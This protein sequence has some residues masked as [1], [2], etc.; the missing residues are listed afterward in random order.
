M[1]PISSK[2]TAMTM[3]ITTKEANTRELCTVDSKTLSIR[4]SKSIF[5]T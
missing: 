5:M 1:R 4:I 3:T 2:I